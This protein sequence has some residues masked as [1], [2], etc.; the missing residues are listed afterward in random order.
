MHILEIPMGE[1]CSQE[2][3]TGEVLDPRYKIVNGYS[4]SEYDLF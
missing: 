3:R 1:G 4:I 2:K